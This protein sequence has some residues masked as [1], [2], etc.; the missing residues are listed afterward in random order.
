MPNDCFLLVSP[1]WFSSLLRC[2]LGF[3]FLLFSSNSKYSSRCKRP[4]LVTSMLNIKAVRMRSGWILIDCT[5]MRTTHVQTYRRT[6]VHTYIRTYVHMCIRTYVHTYYVT[7]GLSMRSEVELVFGRSMVMNITSYLPWFSGGNTSDTLYVCVYYVY[8][9]I[10]IHII[11]VYIYI[12]MYTHSNIIRVIIIVDI[13][14]CIY[15]YI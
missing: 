13:Y 9:Y 5:Y 15:T 11:C 1:L 12:H 3:C 8:I 2:L 4:L 14:V 7:H 6:Y 10:C